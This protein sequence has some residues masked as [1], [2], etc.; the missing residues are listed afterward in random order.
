MKLLRFL[1]VWG[2]RLPWQFS[3]VF[4]LLM[5]IYLVAAS[6]LVNMGGVPTIAEASFKLLEMIGVPKY[7]GGL[8]LVVVL[9]EGLVSLVILL[10]G[11]LL[12]YN[13][14]AFVHRKLRSKPQAPACQPALE[15]S[16]D[17]RRLH[18]FKKIGIILAGGGAKGAYQAGAMKAIHEFLE[19]NNAL[20]KVKM[21]AGTSIGSWNA[22]FWLAGL[23]KSPGPDGMSAH[24]Q[25][26]RSINLARMVEFDNYFPLKAN[27]FV[28]STPWQETFEQVFIQ[29]APVRD[30]LATLFSA[31]APIHFYFT[32]SN[33]ELGHL[34]F[35]TN[36]QEVWSVQPNLRKY[37]YE[38]LVKRDRCEVIDGSNL[39]AAF[40][41]M[42]R[43]VFASMDLPPLFPYVKIKVKWGS[44]SRMAGWWTTSPS[45]SAP[46][47]R[48][49]T[50]SSFCP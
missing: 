9:W 21:I 27:H 16:G 25:W 19:E 23:V 20:G 22:V 44:C 12:N 34:E 6:V 42:K 26:W 7:L 28:L 10:G 2:L 5:L 38:T 40:D 45:G 14:A 13:I 8:P 31:D 18:Q 39:A 37:P 49:A 36:W 47:W 29:S 30:R 50:C 48:S 33:V 4:V 32:R 3:A 24:E 46:S 15:S 35:A 17:G 1:I 41:H 43:A 11:V